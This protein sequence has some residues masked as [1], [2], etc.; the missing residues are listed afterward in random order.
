MKIC[1][2]KDVHKNKKNHPIKENKGVNPHHLYLLQYIQ[3][4]QAFSDII[5][6]T[7]QET[8]NFKAQFQVEE[9]EINIETLVITN[10][11]GKKLLYKYIPTKETYGNRPVMSIITKGLQVSKRDPRSLQQN[12][13]DNKSKK[14]AFILLTHRRNRFPA[15][16]FMNFSYAN[17]EN[18]QFCQVDNNLFVNPSH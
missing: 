1:S 13:S 12:I 4:S 16:I 14:L 6:K 5:I 8:C 11:R 17:V 7:W 15:P 2:Q 9:P 3:A 18:Y 10:F